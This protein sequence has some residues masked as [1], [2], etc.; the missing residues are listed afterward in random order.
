MGHNGVSR[1]TEPTHQE[2]I[3]QSH[4]YLIGAVPAAIGTVAVVVHLREPIVPDEFNA[5]LINATLA[6]WLLTA[7]CAVAQH[8]C[9]RFDRRHDENKALL[10]AHIKASGRDF[11]IAMKKLGGVCKRAD[12]LETQAKELREDL[13]LQNS[14]MR[15][16]IAHL[17]TL[18]VE[19]AP[20]SGPSTYS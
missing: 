15:E 6:C 4:L 5:P 10:R 17:R 14:E 12:A 7:I 3:R 2:P 11:G 13:E 9:S 8:I 20:L 19:Q 16:E 18:I 1:M